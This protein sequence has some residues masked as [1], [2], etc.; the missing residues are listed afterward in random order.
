MDPFDES[1]SKERMDRFLFA[2]V[3]A[4]NDDPPGTDIT[5]GLVMAFVLGRITRAAIEHGIQP[6]GIS[7]YYNKE[8]QRWAV[9]TPA[10]RREQQERQK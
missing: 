5:N 10:M 4:L 7:A 6:A 9:M 1:P 2:V 8:S 3:E